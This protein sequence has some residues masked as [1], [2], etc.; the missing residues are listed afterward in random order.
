[1]CFA[2]CYVSEIKELALLRELLHGRAGV[3][4]VVTDSKACALNLRTVPIDLV[5]SGIT[6][7]GKE[8]NTRPVVHS[9]KGFLCHLGVSL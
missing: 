2:H 7:Q 5:K 1:M 4:A 9:L 6:G 3:S 8:T